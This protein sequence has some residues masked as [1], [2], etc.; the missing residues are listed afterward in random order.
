MNRAKGLDLSYYDISFDPK[1]AT[2]PVDFVIQRVTLGFQSGKIDKDTALDKL[3]TGVQ[4]VGIRGAYHYLS[5][6]SD[7]KAQADFF[8]NVVKNYDYQFYACDFEG[9]YNDMSAKFSQDANLWMEHVAGKTNKKV[10]FYTNKSLYDSFGWMYNSKWPLWLA[11]YWKFPLLYNNPSLPKKC[12]PG[13]WTIWQFASELN[14][15]GHSKEYGC[16]ANSVDINYFNGTIADMQNWLGNT[17]PP[18]PPPTTTWYKV[19]NLVGLNIRSG[20]TTNAPVISWMPNE[21]RF[22]VI[23][24]INASGYIWLELL[25]GGFSAE[26][27]IPTNKIFA[28][29]E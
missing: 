15:P 19:V 21:T 2:Q 14:Y 8:L 1:K 16:G 10:L 9:A 25:N 18:S 29:A 26:K 23:N 6:H 11:Q 27:Y 4:K 24:K 5:T 13:D 22:Q 12:T 20:P 7:W 17:A 3:Y 28:V